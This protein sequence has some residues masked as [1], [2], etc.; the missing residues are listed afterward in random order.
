[1]INFKFLFCKLHCTFLINII[2][3]L[4]EKPFSCPICNKSFSRKANMEMHKVY[5][6]GERRYTCE[7]CGQ[8]F[9]AINALRRHKKLHTGRYL[10]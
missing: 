5:H 2:Y 10:H 6:T 4:G 3:I 7:I 9:F 1:M 8:S